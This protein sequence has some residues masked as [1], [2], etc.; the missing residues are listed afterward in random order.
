MASNKVIASEASK[1]ILDRLNWRLRPPGVRFLFGSL[2]SSTPKRV[3]SGCNSDIKLGDLGGS[4]P[5]ATP[6]GF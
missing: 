6:V 2:K 1:G 5:S 3:P 4:Q